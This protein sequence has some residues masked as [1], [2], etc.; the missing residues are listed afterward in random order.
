MLDQERNPVFAKYKNALVA[1]GVDLS[2]ELVIDYIRNCN[3][4]LEVRFQAII[5]YWYWLQNQQ[6]EL[7]A[8]NQVLMQAFYEQWQPFEWREEFLH[9]D[10]FKSTAEKWWE[11]ARSIDI[12]KN[13]IV[14]VK[15][16]FWF[17]GK[18]IFQNPQGELWSMDLEIAMEMSWEELIAYYQRVTGIV[19]E[20]HPGY[21]LL[22]NRSVS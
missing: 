18:V 4:E 11:Q 12:L 8:P 10:E 21:F 7:V 5:S 19:I 14:D 17:G 6:R 20:S 22:H 13:L 3:Y 1:I 9:N 2:D 16:N 15:D